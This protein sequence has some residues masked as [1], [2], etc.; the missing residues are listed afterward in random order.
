VA[1]GDLS[2]AA[3]LLVPASAGYAPTAD[4]SLGYDTTQGAWVGGGAGGIVGRF[5]RIL[6]A[7]QS[8]TDTI[9]DDAAG[10]V[11]TQFTQ[12]FSVPANFFT[13]N[14]GLLIL[15][16]FQI[17][18]LVGPPTLRID[19]RLGTTSV[20]Q[21][22][23]DTPG[24]SLTTGG[25]V[26][27]LIMGTAAPGASVAVFTSVLGGSV[28]NRG[29]T[30]TYWTNQVAYTQAV[31]TNGALT[32]NVTALWGSNVANTHSIRLQSLIVMEVN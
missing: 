1:K 15:A 22:W 2:A 16:G 29:M 3:S 17:A 6:K 5:P 9:T 8:S 20:V 19:I 27:A 13:A 12:T 26:A 7:T 11:Q 24:A 23:T 31:A 21:S 30:A 10:G 32:L 18:S 28:P 14:K 4:G 25:G